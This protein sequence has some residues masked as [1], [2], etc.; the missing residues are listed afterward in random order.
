MSA[1]PKYSDGLLY[2]LREVRDNL[3]EQSRYKLDAFSE[4]IRSKLLNS[5]LSIRDAIESELDTLFEMRLI[6]L[7]FFLRKKQNLASILEETAFPYFE[8]IAQTPRLEKLAN[9]VIE[10]L[11]YVQLVQ[12]A[13]SPPIQTNIE[14]GEISIPH[15][16]LSDLRSSLQVLPLPNESIQ[17]LE[18]LTISSLYIEYVICSVSLIYDDHIMIQGDRLQ[19]LYFTL[20]D[21]SAAYAAL[22]IEAG[23]IPDRSIKLTPPTKTKSKGAF[24]FEK[25]LSDKREIHEH[26]TSGGTL[27]ALN[28]KFRFVTPL[29][30]GNH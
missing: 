16:T 1:I 29:S 27:S 6:G 23:I 10:A 9:K 30:T 21:A 11:R 3:D 24:L 4:H 8:N 5:S 17:I 2:Q 26:L 25:A 7:Y 20:S 18:D 14:N 15:I 13:I 28:K 22:A 12:K 19:E